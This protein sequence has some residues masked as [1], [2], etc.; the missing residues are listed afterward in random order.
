TAVNRDGSLLGMRLGRSNAFLET[1][2]DFNQIQSFPGLDSGVAFD[3]VKDI[4]YGVN[5]STG[6]IIAYDTNNFAEKFRFDIGEDVSAGSTQFGVGLLVPSQDGR[7]LALIAPTAV[8]V[9]G[10][11]A[12]QLVSISSVKSHRNAGVFG[13]DLPLNGPR[14]VECRGGGPSGQYTMIF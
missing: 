4:F 13:I 2:P 3:A 7:Y 6:Q 9:F 5:S 12:V 8:R 11:P 14:G 1:A 10:V